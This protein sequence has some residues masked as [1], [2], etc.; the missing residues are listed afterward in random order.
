MELNT[1]GFYKKPRVVP[2]MTFLAHITNTRKCG[3]RMPLG[4][5][6]GSKRKMI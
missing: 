3:N 2:G 5:Q 1:E 4:K 6:S